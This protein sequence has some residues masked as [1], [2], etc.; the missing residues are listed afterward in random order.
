MGWLPYTVG[1][2]LVL[3]TITAFGMLVSQLVHERRSVTD[4]GAGCFWC[5]PHLPWKKGEDQ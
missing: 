4:H 2:L 3:A 5:H 1:L